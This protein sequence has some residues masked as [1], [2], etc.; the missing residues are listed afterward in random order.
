MFRLVLCES[1]ICVTLAECL[2]ETTSLPLVG[3]VRFACTLTSPNPTSLG[4]LLF[5]VSS[6]KEGLN[7]DIDC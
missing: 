7:I 3:R 4:M 5:Y 2:S 6:N 1:L